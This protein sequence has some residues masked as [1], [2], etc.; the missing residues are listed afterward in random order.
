MIDRLLLF[1]GVMKCFL[2]ALQKKSFH[3]FLANEFELFGKKIWKSELFL[4]FDFLGN[5]KML[6]G[7]GFD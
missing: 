6:L 1:F 3:T 5:E 7:T 2:V 4:F